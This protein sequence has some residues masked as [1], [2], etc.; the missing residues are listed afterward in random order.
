L[1][2]LARSLRAMPGLLSLSSAHVCV[3]GMAD[4][5]AALGSLAGLRSLR[6]D[7]VPRP[8]RVPGSPDT[9]AALCAA[10]SSLTELRVLSLPF[11]VVPFEERAASTRVHRRGLHRPLRPR[12]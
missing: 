7:G 5:S 6:L 3:S 11:D 9:C 12:E 1:A 10:L 4:L 2:A 8:G